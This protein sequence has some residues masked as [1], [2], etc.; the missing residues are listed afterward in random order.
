MCTDIVTCVLSCSD[1]WCQ[2]DCLVKDL[3]Q[4]I[5]AFVDLAACGVKNGCVAEYQDG[6]LQLLD[7][8]C[9]KNHCGPELGACLGKTLDSLGL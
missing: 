4:A 1:V 8:A 5:E 2:K 9:V 6:Y 7:V 3:A